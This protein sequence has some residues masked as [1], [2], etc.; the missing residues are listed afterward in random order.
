MIDG[1]S[2]PMRNVSDMLR[3]FAIDKLDNFQ[4]KWLASPPDSPQALAQ[5]YMNYAYYV[6][7]PCFL[8]LMPGSYVRLQG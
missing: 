5:K 2:A 3:S 7:A 8:Q 6:S 4:A 1:V